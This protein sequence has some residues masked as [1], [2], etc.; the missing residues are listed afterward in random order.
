MKFREKDIKYCKIT[1]HFIFNKNL[2]CVENKSRYIVYYNLTNK[3]DQTN[4]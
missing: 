2:L 3:L 1:P 4:I